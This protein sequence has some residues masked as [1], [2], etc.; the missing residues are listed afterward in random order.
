MELKIK[1]AVILNT[2]WRKKKNLEQSFD[3]LDKGR[4]REGGY[5]IRVWHRRGRGH[6]LGGRLVEPR[7]TRVW[8]WLHTQLSTV[9]ICRSRC[10]QDY[11]PLGSWSL[12]IPG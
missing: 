6:L 12:K 9:S 10:P 5:V 8:S 2:D 11:I 4:D 1:V 3:L 7:K